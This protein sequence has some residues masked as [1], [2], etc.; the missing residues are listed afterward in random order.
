M[1]IKVFLIVVIKLTYTSAEK[2]DS[3]PML[4]YGACAFTYLTAMLASNKALQWVSYPTQVNTNDYG[5]FEIS[6][7][8]PFFN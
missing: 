4:W 7:N 3:T 1:M 6:F 5:L 2:K 8:C